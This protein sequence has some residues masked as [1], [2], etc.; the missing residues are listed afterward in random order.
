[1]PHV[2]FLQ[3]VVETGP[4]PLWWLWVVIAAAFILTIVYLL[5]RIG[6]GGPGA[7]S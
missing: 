4:V 2:L 6:P 1:M 7:P 3:D 5:K